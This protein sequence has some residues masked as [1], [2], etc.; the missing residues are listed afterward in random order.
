LCGIVLCF[1]VLV[2]LLGLPVSLV[3][4]G[5]GLDGRGAE[6][7][8]GVSAVDGHGGACVRQVLPCRD[9]PFSFAV[10]QCG[11]VIL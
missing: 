3:N 7:F 8:G 2:S 5:L 10:V 6:C 4:C 11:E 9:R 1:H